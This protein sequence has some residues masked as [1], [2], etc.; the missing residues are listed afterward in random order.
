MSENTFYYSVPIGREPL[1]Y[2]TWD[3]T[4]KNISGYSGAKYKK[5]KNY[6]EAVNFF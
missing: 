1:I 2:N 5:F 4:Q 3:E 6:E